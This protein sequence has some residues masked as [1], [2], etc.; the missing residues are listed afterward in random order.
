MDI[1]VKKDHELQLFMQ[2]TK[3]NTKIKSKWNIG[4]DVTAK[5]IKVLKENTRENLCQ[6]G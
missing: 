4:L 1:S 5:G 2:H 6:A 3:L